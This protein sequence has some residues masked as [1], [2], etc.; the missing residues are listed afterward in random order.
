MHLFSRVAP[1][2][3]VFF[4]F[5]AVTASA[6]PANDNDFPAISSQSGLPEVQTDPAPR[7]TE[8]PPSSGVQNLLEGSLLGKMFFNMPFERAS[9]IDILTLLLLAFIISKIITRSSSKGKTPEK[10]DNGYRWPSNENQQNNTPAAPPPGFDPW[11][12]LRSNQSQTQKGK[13]IPFPGV[14]PSPRDYYTPAALHPENE[15]EARHTNDDFLKGAKLIYVRLHEAWKNQD[16]EFI[17]HFTSPQAYQKFLQTD[18]RNYLDIVKVEA[19]IIKESRRNGDPFITVE[20]NALA[21][22]SGRAGPPV[23]LK[24]IWSFLEPASTGTWRLEEF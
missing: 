18:K 20:F 8:A 21:H 3:F 11:A 13:T 17:E 15:P 5:S 16:L 24:E 19:T 14:K 7:L 2:L 4:I 6:E 10:N 22:Q 23:E 9:M 1:L 12:R